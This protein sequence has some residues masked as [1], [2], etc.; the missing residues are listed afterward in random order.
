MFDE[1]PELLLPPPELPGANIGGAAIFGAF[2]APWALEF[3][4][5]LAAICAIYWLFGEP[6][7]PA[8]DDAPPGGDAWPP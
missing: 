5:M 3:F 7:A 1:L 8:D 2:D 4:G 6:G